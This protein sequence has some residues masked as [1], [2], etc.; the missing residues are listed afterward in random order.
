MR[1][2]SSLLWQAVKNVSTFSRKDGWAGGVRVESTVSG[3]LTLTTSDDFVGIKAVVTLLEYEG[4]QEFYLS[5]ESIRELEKW[6]RDRNEEIECMLTEDPTDRKVFQL[7][8]VS[9]EELHPESLHWAEV[10]DCPSEEWWSMFEYI[11]HEASLRQHTPGPSWEIDPARLSKLSL[12][13]P[14]AKF[15]VSWKSVVIDNRQ[16]EAFKYGPDTYGVI[17]TL[18]REELEKVYK[19]RISEVLWGYGWG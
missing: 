11:L 19:D 16:I 14:K 15:P 4:L 7:D 1:V 6:L 3:N 18:N 5:H 9:A 8:A 12:L 13:E 2:D 10:I 17:M